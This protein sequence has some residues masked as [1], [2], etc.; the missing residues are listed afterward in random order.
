MKYIK[1]TVIAVCLIVL[2]PPTVSAKQLYKW[3]DKDG[4]VHV[5]DN[6]ESIPSEYRS[7]AVKSKPKS[8]SGA[9]IERIESGFKNAFEEISRHAKENIKKVI[10]GT[11]VIIGLIA[12]VYLLRSYLKFKEQKERERGLRA[13]EILNIDGISR[14]EFENYVIRLL[15]HRGFKVETTGE[16]IAL[17]VTLIAKKDEHQYA[18]QIERQTGAVSRLTVSDVDREKHRYGCDK[19]I[20]ITNSHFSEDA[21]ELARLKGFELVDRDTLAMWILN[22]QTHGSNSV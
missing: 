5:T 4:V 9:T 22:F 13:L 11:L 1:F 19:V 21:I 15:T 2:M 20:L 3:V 8:R 16:K 7:S 10:A 12:L 14:T 18:V 17:G 6:P